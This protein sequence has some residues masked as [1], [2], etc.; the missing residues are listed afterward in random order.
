M[1]LMTY[2]G[3][4][5]FGFTPPP[6][7][8]GPTTGRDIPLA[9][10]QS[11]VATDFQNYPVDRMKE[12]LAEGWAHPVRA[13]TRAL[14]RSRTLSAR[15]SARSSSTAR[16]RRKRMPYFPGWGQQGTGEYYYRLVAEHS[17]GSG[18]QRD[19]V[20]QLCNPGI[21]AHAGVGR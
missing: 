6:R 11:T 13:D 5:G 4:S 9:A 16:N 17:G 7:A 3:H 19:T 18:Q 20:D 8:A 2:W 1:D 10:P 21:E 15:K 12:L 14:S